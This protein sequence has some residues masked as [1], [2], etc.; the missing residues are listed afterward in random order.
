MILEMTDP[1]LDFVTLDTCHAS[2]GRFDPVKFL[3]DSLRASRISTQG[4]VACLGAREGMEGPPRQEEEAAMAKKLGLPLT[5]DPIYQRL[6][7]AASIF[8]P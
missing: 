1:K 2:V 7:T 4:Y 6:G 3:R 8:L 5:S